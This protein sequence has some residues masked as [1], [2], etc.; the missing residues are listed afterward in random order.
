MNQT[1]TPK[2]G[3]EFILTQEDPNLKA[4]QKAAAQSLRSPQW[5]CQSGPVT[6]NY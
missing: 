1:V 3:P 5:H 2:I 6:G 4:A